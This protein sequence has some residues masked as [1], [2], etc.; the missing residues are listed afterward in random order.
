VAKRIS[1]KKLIDEWFKTV[2]P[3]LA[4]RDS[5]L[6]PPTPDAQQERRI[7]TQK[8]A[9]LLAKPLIKHSKDRAWTPTTTKIGSNC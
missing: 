6:A 2:K 5:Q 4:R 1:P 8:L 9:R 7:R 3:H